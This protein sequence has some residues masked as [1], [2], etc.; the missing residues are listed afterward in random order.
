MRL[1]DL[2]YARWRKSVPSAAAACFKT[3][4]RVKMIHCLKEGCG[5]EKSSEIMSKVSVIGAGLAGCEAAWAL[6]RRGIDVTLYEMK[7]VKYSPAHHYEGFAEL[8]CSNSLKAMRLNS[9]AGL[10]KAEMKADGFAGGAL[11]RADRSARP[12]EPWRWTGRPFATLVTKAHTGACRNVTVVTGEVTEIPAGTVI[13]ATG[14]LTSEALSE[15]IGRL[16]GEKYLSFY[17]ASAPIVTKD[18]I[19]M[20]RVYFATRYDRGE[21]DYINCS[22]QQRG[23]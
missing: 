14:P 23:V 8:V 17:D 11:R 10:L 2:G 12:A 4:G 21:A 9:A 19:D 13:V 22:V 16:C 20:E 7:P 15:T 5:Y 6:A 18:S 1:Y 3:T